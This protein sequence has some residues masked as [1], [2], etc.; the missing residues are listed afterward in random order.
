MDPQQRL[1]LEVAWETVENAGQSPDELA[2]APVGV[3]V[4]I[5]NSDYVHL[6][7]RRGPAAIDTHTGTG[8]MNSIAAGRLAYVLGIQ[9]PCLSV[10]T[11][12]SSSL[13]A[14][15]LAVQSLREGHCQTALAGGVNLILD[16]TPML[17]LSRLRALSLD[18]R[19]KTFDAAADGY[20]RGEG[21]GL[22]LLKRLSDAQKDGDRILAVIRGS[23]INHDG[24][25][26]GLTAPNRQAQEAVIRLALEEAGVEP[27]A[28]SYLE[29]HGT[30]TLL[31]D[32]IEVRAA[33]AVYGQGRSPEQPLAVG[34]V[35]TNIGHLE[36]AAGVA[37]LLKVV[38]ALQHKAIPAHLNLDDPNPYIPWDDMSV[39]VPTELEE[40]QPVNGCHLAGVSSFGLSGTNA[41]LLVERY[42]QPQAAPSRTDRPRHLL[43]L[44][45]KEPEALQCLAESYSHRLCEPNVS[46]ADICY[47]ASTG[48]ARL[49]HRAAIVAG[50]TDEA[51]QLLEAMNAGKRK[52]TVVSGVS[53]SRNPARLAMLFTGQGSQYAGMGRQ[54][55]ETQ[56]TFWRVINECDVLLQDE[57]Q[58]P[59]TSVLYPEDAQDERMADSTY[60]Q[61]A[62]FAVELALYEL[63]KSWGVVSEFVMGHSLGEYA[64]AC[65][66]GIFSWEDALRLV[67]ARGRLMHELPSNGDMAAV[68]ASEQIVRQHIEACDEPVAI[69]AVN[70]PE[71]TV[72]SGSFTAIETALTRLKHYGIST[73]QLAVTHAFHS[74]S[75][76]PMLDEFKAICQ[77][78]DFAPPKIPIADNVQGEVRGDAMASPDYWRQQIREAVRFGDAIT[79]LDALG[80]NVYLEVGPNTTLAGL[81]KQCVAGEERLWLSS[82]RP[83]RDDWSAMLQGLAELF[84]RGVNIDWRGFD[85]DYERR[86][87]TL[88]NYPFQRKRYWL[89]DIEDT[90]PLGGEVMET[91][92]SSPTVD[93]QGAF[94]ELQWHP[95]SRWDQRVSNQV[96]ADYPTPEIVADKVRAET[97]RVRS[98]FSLER[99]QRLGRDLDQ[100]SIGYVFQALRQSGWNAE[101]GSHMSTCEQADRLEIVPTQRRLFD[102]ILE[103]LSEEG[104]L[105]ADGDKWSVVA[106]LPRIGDLEQLVSKLEQDYPE[107]SAELGLLN[108]CGSRLAEVLRGMADPLQVLFPSGSAEA[109]EKLYCDSPFARTLN[110]LVAATVQSF[111]TSFP[112][113]RPIRVL[114]IGA[115]TGGTTAHLLPLLPADRTEYL[116]TDVSELFTRAAQHKFQEFPFVRYG[117]LDIETDSRE[118]GFADQRFDLI[119]AANVLHATRDLRETLGHARQLL[120][121]GGS[122]VVLESTRPQRWLD[123]VFGLTDGWWRFSDRDLRSNH[124][125][126]PPKQWREL[127]RFCGFESAVAL[128]ETLDNDLVESPPQ[129]VL[130]ARADESV[131][132]SCETTS[133]DRTEL[134]QDIGSWLILADQG[135]VGD[136]LAGRLT[137]LGG[138]AICVTAGDGIA[139]ALGQFGDDPCRGVVHL[140]SLDGVDGGEWSSERLQEVQVRGAAS[141]PGLLQALED[142]C[143]N[144]KPRIWFVTGGAQPV[145]DGLAPSGLAQSPLW[146]I[147]RVV[148]GELPGFWGGLVDLDAHAPADLAAE[149]LLDEIMSPD[150]EDQIAYRD[151]QRYAA[152]LA[153]R[154][155]TGTATERPVLCRADG[156]Y[157]VTGGL[158]DLGLEIAEWLVAKGAKSLVL[159]ARR[160]ISG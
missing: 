14:V 94:F 150:G 132:C 30:G 153:P 146:G 59:L 7:N 124:A 90:T 74:P 43:V 9:G 31:G 86:K 158:G 103:M 34:S 25:S 136:I 143:G 76:E 38:L 18:G 68:A 39:R 127:L 41:H 64:A 102:R 6:Q 135:G 160:T 112:T 40:W 22:V 122:L 65:A 109:V 116:F 84:V 115:G 101:P 5:S 35:K 99:Y 62:L 52:A 20:G 157:L 83:R 152:R 4:G 88:P 36:S 11:A 119:L 23:A 123:L 147:A 125:L 28:V 2:S 92:H 66:A 96:T 53:D 137:R 1:L 121:P 81:G 60:A 85:R 32:P 61:P 42:E 16:P 91:R 141:V 108:Q 75:M 114:E 46:L 93:M 154:R 70:G 89:D 15:H 130:V 138:K 10:D 49:K 111:A 126:L 131:T 50:D 133:K 19:C 21:C 12:C 97:D 78:V 67:A 17:A 128:P 80:A 100:L 156:S 37:G 134:S 72:I 69:S 44:S 54:L 63:W 56:P 71:Q 29:A 149:Q 33:D 110:A 155:I 57:L 142:C 151:V 82:L 8:T 106:Q 87:V 145:G 77:T 148:A 55:Y 48:R 129:A 140:W 120:A 47:T 107:C 58:Q 159:T 104:L 113:S 105:A 98:Q 79:A 117:L 27:A 144:Q 3:F 24:R 95:R 51:V 139:D 13:V 45:A 26:N 118:Q 73:S